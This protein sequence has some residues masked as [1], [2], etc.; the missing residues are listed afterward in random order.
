M[1]LIVK[2]QVTGL[3]GLDASCQ[4]GQEVC[5][6]WVCTLAAVFVSRSGVVCSPDVVCCLAAVHPFLQG[7]VP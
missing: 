1:H 2:P 7:W 5:T 4:S 3:G 6:Q